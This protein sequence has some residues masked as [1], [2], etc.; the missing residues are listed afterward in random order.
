MTGLWKAMT[1]LYPNA[2]QMRDFDI[3][4][5]DG[6]EQIVNWRLGGNPPSDAELTAAIAA[7]DAAATAQQAEAATLRQQVI[8]QANSAAGVLISA[9]TA[10]QVR[11]LLAILLWK[12]GALKADGTVRALTEWV[13]D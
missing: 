7:Y 3:I 12:T 9:L 10:G 8:T 2:V 4:S 5:R 1:Q 6:I 13:K 11:S